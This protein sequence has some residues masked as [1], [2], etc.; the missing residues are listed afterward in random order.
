MP[1]LPSRISID[2]GRIR[3]RLDRRL[4]GSFL[5]HLG[6]AVYGGVFDPGSPRSDASGF[7]TDLLQE[8]RQLGVPIVRYPGG[9]FVSGY[10]WLDGVG[11]VEDRPTMLDRAWNSLDSN[12]FGTNEFMRWCEL[13][14][15]EPMLVFNLGSNTAEGAAAY[16]DYCNGAGGTRW[17]NLRRAHGVE[18]PYGVRHWCLGNELDG[19]W[20]I[21]HMN[22]VEYGRLAAET[23][24]RVRAVDR[25]V[26]LIAAGSSN[27]EIST[28][29]RWDRDLL[30]ECYDQVDAISLHNYYGNEPE[31]TGGDSARYLAMN[32]D[33]E[34]QIHTIAGICD[35]VQKERRSRKRLWLSF[36]E[37]NVWYRARSPEH[38]DGQGRL[39]PHLLEETY[40]LEDALL[41]GGLLNSLMR[42]SDR[43]RI[44]CQAQLVNVIA[45]LVSNDDGLLRQSIYFP[46]AWAL[47]HAG[48]TV[49]D[50]V[51]ACESYAIEAGDLRHDFARD[52]QVPFIDASVTLDDAGSRASVFVLNRDL[53]ENR[54]L[55]LEW[56]GLEPARVLGCKTLSG[57]DLKAANTFEQPHRVAP[58]VLDPPRCGQ[59]M[60]MELPAASYTVLDVAL[61]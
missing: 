40:N 8:V 16:V 43:V 35:E 30:R 44:A 46:Y 51:C 59:T 20:Q 42:E 17:S 31:L 5:E 22:A 56:T 11:P 37:W 23:A 61:N 19:P 3:A 2:A 1:R 48:G 57:P 39:A 49:L 28:F 60:T 53:S 10:N 58:Q 50:C 14:G 25:D 12:Q 7:R 47:E 41:V 38:M 21:G 9:N 18:A 54:E 13:V 32:L 4:F 55:T 45:P 33:M 36:D 6:R 52:A 34:R 24:K 26:Q 29:G 27:T 15:T